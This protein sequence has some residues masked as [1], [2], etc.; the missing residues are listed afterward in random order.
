[1]LQIV[2]EE[3]GCAIGCG[4]SRCNCPAHRTPP[5]ETLRNWALPP[6]SQRQS[7]LRDDHGRRLSGGYD[8]DIQLS[9]VVGPVLSQLLT[10]LVWPV[11]I[12]THRAGMMV[13][14]E[15]THSR[16]PLSVDRDMVGREVPILRTAT[17]RAYLAFC[18][19]QERQEILQCIRTQADPDDEPYLI[20]GAV[21]E[22]LARCRQMGTGRG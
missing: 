8:T 6:Q 14:R 2:N 4:A 18:P 13:V 20:A 12:A 15:T 19:E 7:L 3:G 22:M 17:G 16:S 11:N 1:L 10:D 9:E 5:V 21:D